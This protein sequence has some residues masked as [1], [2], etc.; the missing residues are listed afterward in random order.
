M[1]GEWRVLGRRVGTQGIAQSRDNWSVGGNL[2]SEAG[3]APRVL[4]KSV[5]SA[6]SS[7]RHVI[8]RSGCFV[9]WF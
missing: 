9:Y 6:M 5:L 3:K 4:E 2:T 8:V 1:G 7:V